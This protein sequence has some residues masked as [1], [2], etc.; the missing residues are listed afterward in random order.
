MSIS[1][2]KILKSPSDLVFRDV[3]SLIFSLTIWRNGTLGVQ[4]ET[5]GLPLIYD[6]EMTRILR[7][8][9]KGKES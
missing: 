9:G 7:N 3:I 5:L 6:V 8:E 2:S 4:K 1:T